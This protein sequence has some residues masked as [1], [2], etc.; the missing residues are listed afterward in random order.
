VP[1]IAVFAV[2]V[3]LGSFTVKQQTAA[4]VER[5][6]KFTTCVTLDYGSKYLLLTGCGSYQSQG[7]SNWTCRGTKT[8]DD[9]FV[10][11]KILIQFNY[12]KVYD[13]FLQASKDTTDNILCFF[14]GACRGA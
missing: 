11:L 6:G 7:S 10:R 2:I 14:D 12:D 13:A 4:L 9:V 8:K 1:V 3:L 5:F